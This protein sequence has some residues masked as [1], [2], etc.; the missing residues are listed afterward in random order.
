[1]NRQRSE[2][3]LREDI[4]TVLLALLYAVADQDDNDWR[5]GYVHALEAVAMAFGVGVKV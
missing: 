2:V 4:R 3:Y 1:M 5:R